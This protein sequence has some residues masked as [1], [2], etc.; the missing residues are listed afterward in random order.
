MVIVKIR[1]LMYAI[2]SPYQPSV[3]LINETG[4]VL[5]QLRYF[6][7]FKIKQFTVLHLLQRVGCSI[8]VFSLK[9]KKKSIF[10]N[11]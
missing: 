1:W 9:M 4:Q 3:L 8:Q 5:N 2:R 11:F 7:K 10:Q 6:V